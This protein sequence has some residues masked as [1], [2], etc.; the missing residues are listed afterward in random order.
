M[1]LRRSLDAEHELS[2]CQV[3]EGTFTVQAFH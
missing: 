3:R 1:P 2:T